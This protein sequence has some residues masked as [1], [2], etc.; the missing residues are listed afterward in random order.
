[1]NKKPTK[2]RRSA[3]VI[4]VIAAVSLIVTGTLAWRSISQRAVNNT[5]GVPE[6]PG[7]RLHDDFLET[8]SFL[9]ANGGGNKDVYVENFS[10]QSSVDPDEVGRPV[11]VRV[12]LSEYMEIGQGAGLFNVDPIVGDPQDYQD[13]DQVDTGG[14]GRTVDAAN[15]ATPVIPDD[16]DNPGTPSSILDLSTWADHIPDGNVAD[17]GSDL[18]YYWDWN[19]GGSKI[20]LPTFN[21]DNESL[22]TD[23]TDNDLDDDGAVDEYSDGQEVI[24]PANYANGAVSPADEHHFAKSTLETAGV[25]TMDEWLDLDK[26]QQDAANNAYWVAD[27]DG[28]FY[29]SRALMPTDATGLLLNGIT[30]L[31]E[32]DNEWYYGIHVT[33]QMASAGDWGSNAAGA[34][35]G[36]YEDGITANGLDLL[37]RAANL[38]PAVRSIQI[39]EGRRVFVTAGNNI[40]LHAD[41]SVL[42][43]SGDINETLVTWSV[44][45]AGDLT[46]EGELRTVAGDAGKIYTVTASSPALPDVKTDSIRVIVLPLGAEGVVEGVDGLTY[47][48][49]GDNIYRKVNNDGTIVADYRY[50]GAD[51]IIG[52]ADDNYTAHANAAGVRMLGP[53]AD[54]GSY[55]IAGAD[56]DLGTADDE[57]RWPCPTV[58]NLGVSPVSYIALGDTYIDRNGVE[59][60]VINDD[61]SGHKLIMTTAVYEAGLKYNI[62]NDWSSLETSNLMTASNGLH[63]F[64]QNSLGADIKAGAV[65]HSTIT[66]ARS[67]PDVSFDAD[68]NVVSDRT[69][70]G[71]GTPEVDG[72]GTIFVLS[73]SEYNEYRGNIA[74]ADGVC[75]LR[76]AGGTA[77]Y[78]MSIVYANGDIYYD[79]A[80]NTGMGCRPAMWI[81][82]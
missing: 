19:M 27:T 49:Y 73:I 39:Q 16:P 58:D 2:R 17:D 81:R 63:N 32:P 79:S 67:T 18:H 12:R 37:N 15:L 56:G 40:T 66:Y 75:W 68:E 44:D 42:N 31:Q 7:A 10:G 80:S 30:M 64:Y 24:G 46:P 23:R 47:M 28:W 78:P 70:A 72:N 77:R 8:Q 25:I 38:A 21:K 65:P 74:L 6:E 48:S 14:T 45:N 11:Y 3:G 13:L 20:F 50:A 29:W 36:F 22:L 60:Q 69:T 82:S 61:G 76:S 33:S 26:P 9:A 59:W 51:R 5:R 62:T 34:E 55:S 4:A 54:D 52:N 35:T 71:G 57:K 41:I 43:A 53:N 1:M